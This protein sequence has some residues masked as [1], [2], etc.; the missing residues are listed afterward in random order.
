MI[1][2]RCVCCGNYTLIDEPPGTFEVCPV[3]FWED[4][5]VQFDDPD[6][7]G[8]A[9]KVSLNRAKENYRTIGAS[10]NDNLKHVRKPSSDETS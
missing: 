2:Y 9:N 4:D 3:C 10:S 6:Y 5:N 1:K 8:G 7:E